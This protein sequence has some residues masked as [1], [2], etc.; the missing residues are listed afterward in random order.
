MLCG[1]KCVKEKRHVDEWQSNM[2]T[3]CERTCWSKMKEH[4]DQTW[5][6]NCKQRSCCVVT[7]RSR[8]KDMICQRGLKWRMHE[9]MKEAQRWKVEPGKAG[10]R[11]M[12]KEEGRGR[13]E[14]KVRVFIP[15]EGV[16][17][18]Q[19]H[20]WYSESANHVKLHSTRM[21]TIWC[22]SSLLGDLVMPPAWFFDPRE[23]HSG[24]S[25]QDEPFRLL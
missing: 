10:G 9:C 18:S 25:Y 23:S 14:E 3:K 17:V 5:K 2:L 21:I 19:D 15:L 22:Q 20:T 11:V 1:D 4:V 7:R 8:R 12:R 24:S 6:K 16:R 13:E